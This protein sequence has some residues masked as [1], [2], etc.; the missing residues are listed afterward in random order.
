MKHFQITVREIPNNYIVR[1][2]YRQTYEIAADNATSA[3]QIA[4]DKFGD[5]STVREGGCIEFD[6][7]YPIQTAYALND[8]E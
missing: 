7:D 6:P 4:L 3:K 2:S 1:Q 5:Y 8:D